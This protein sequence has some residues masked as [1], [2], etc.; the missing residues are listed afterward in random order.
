MPHSKATCPTSMLGII[1][2]RV[3]G[4]THSGPRF[5]RTAMPSSREWIPPIPV[6]KITPTR[7]GLA[8]TSNFEDS[9]A[10]AVATRASWVTRSRCL[11]RRRPKTNSGSKLRTSAAMRTA[12][13]AASKWVIGPTPERPETTPSHVDAAVKPSG[14]TAP[15]P[16][17]TTRRAD[18]SGDPTVR[19]PTGLVRRRLVDRLDNGAWLW[20]SRVGAAVQRSPRRL[21]IG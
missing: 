10:S 1:I 8:L 5:S 14:L 3:Y 17:T 9:M 15:M 13:P 7:S 11:A 2:G 18:M 4:L 19:P 16:V 6:P 20:S 12:N 21:A